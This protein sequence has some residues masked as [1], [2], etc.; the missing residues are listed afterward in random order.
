MNT[1]AVAEEAAVTVSLLIDITFQFPFLLWVKE[2][3]QLFSNLSAGFRY[4]KYS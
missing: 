4:I 1:W 2:C 3:K